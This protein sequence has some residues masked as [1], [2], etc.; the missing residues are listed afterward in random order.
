MRL[1]ANETL[2]SAEMHPRPEEVKLVSSMYVR[3]GE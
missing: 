3:L 1:A 2:V